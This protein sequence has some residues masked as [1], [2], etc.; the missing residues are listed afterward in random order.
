VSGD[1][2][3]TNIENTS[4]MYL[5]NGT[6]QRTGGFESKIGNMANRQTTIQFELVNVAVEKEPR[7]IDNGTIHFTMSGGSGRGSFSY[8]GTITFTGNGEAIIEISGNRYVTNLETGEVE[9]Q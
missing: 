1:F 4:D 5:I 3:I 7:E 6:W 2:E 8:E 9:E